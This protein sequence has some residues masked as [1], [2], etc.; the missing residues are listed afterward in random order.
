MERFKR[1]QG[2]FWKYLITNPVLDEVD[3][4]DFGV[5]CLL[6]QI[7]HEVV[8]RDLNLLNHYLSFHFL[9]A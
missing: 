7:H 8:H 4:S 2:A 1:D 5:G 3:V 9:K 6:L